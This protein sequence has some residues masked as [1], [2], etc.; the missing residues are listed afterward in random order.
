MKTTE[1]ITTEATTTLNNVGNSTQNELD[2][3]STPRKND[4]ITDGSTEKRPT[5]RENGGNIHESGYKE[6]E[7][8][9]K[10]RNEDS[11]SDSS[12][13]RKE[14]NKSLTGMKNYEEISEWKKDNLDSSA[15]E[16][17][18]EAYNEKKK[19]NPNTDNSRS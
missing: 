13:E 16:E 9:G 19:P 5:E 18:N 7:S 2:L 8:N 12:N 11:K 14:I 1:G 17:I 4:E 10:T 15:T 6:S 3:P